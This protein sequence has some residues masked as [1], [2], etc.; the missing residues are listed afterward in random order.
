M[1]NMTRHTRVPDIITSRRANGKDVPT[2]DAQLRRG[3]CAPAS[4][5]KKP[6]RLRRERRRHA[7]PGS[8]PQ[9][10]QTDKS[11]ASGR[12]RFASG[13]APLS[14]SSARRQ[15]PTD[16][17]SSAAPDKE[18]RKTKRRAQ[19]SFPRPG[20]KAPRLRANLPTSRRAWLPD[21]LPRGPRDSP[22]RAARAPLP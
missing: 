2:A 16:L 14:D 9:A 20:G 4:A 3:R 12:A 21:R 17:R 13:A 11:R 10:R 18:T 7:Q 6:S 5:G 15:K 22:P 8:A 19:P 1:F